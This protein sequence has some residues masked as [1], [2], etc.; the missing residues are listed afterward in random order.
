MP[1]MDCK[2][3]YLPFP[4][5]CLSI[6]SSEDT[7]VKMLVGC[8]KEEEGAG[9]ASMATVAAAASFQDQ[10]YCHPRVWQH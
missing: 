5:S 4:Y 6:I 10:D 1:V 9:I 7:S 8:A 2:Q 3:S